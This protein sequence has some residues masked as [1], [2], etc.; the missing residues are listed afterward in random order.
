LCSWSGFWR[1]VWLNCCV[2]GFS[3]AELVYFTC[4]LG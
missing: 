3:R 1:W 2:S 4:F